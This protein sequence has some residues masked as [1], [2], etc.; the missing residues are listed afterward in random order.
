[1]NTT[2]ILLGSIC[3]PKLETLVDEIASNGSDVVIVLIICI[4]VLTIMT[5]ICNLVSYYLKEKGTITFK[6]EEEKRFHD[7]CYEMV[8]STIKDDLGIKKECWELLR[9]WHDISDTNKERDEN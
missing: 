3:C 9:K 5:K 8:K 4:T 7:F 2:F 6:Q 1:M